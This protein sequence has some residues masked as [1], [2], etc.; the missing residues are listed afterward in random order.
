LGFAAAIMPILSKS[1]G[2]NKPQYPVTK[3]TRLRHGANARQ[4]RAATDLTG[5]AL[6]PFEEGHPLGPQAFRRGLDV[7]CGH[8]ADR[9]EWRAT[10]NKAANMYAFEIAL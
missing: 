5:N 3:S 4:R 2:G 1:V 9:A 8:D 10:W 6:T 7:P